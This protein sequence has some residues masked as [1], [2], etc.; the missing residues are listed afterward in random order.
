MDKV[1]DMLPKKNKDKSEST[2]IR[3]ERGVITTDARD[4]KRVIKI[5]YE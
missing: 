4:I 5:Y 3:N 2:D 1:V